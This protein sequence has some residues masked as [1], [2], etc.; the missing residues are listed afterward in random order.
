[1]VNRGLEFF[2]SIPSLISRRES[3]EQLGRKIEQT[4]RDNEILGMGLPW[5]VKECFGL[6]VDGE[7]KTSDYIRMG[8]GMKQLATVLGRHPDLKGRNLLPDA[9]TALLATRARSMAENNVISSDLLRELPFLALTVALKEE[10]E[11]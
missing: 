6:E 11:K 4:D 9:I 1:M 2:R 5:Y 3:P 7:L 10:Q 8:A